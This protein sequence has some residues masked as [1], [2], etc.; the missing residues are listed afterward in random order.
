[1]NTVQLGTELAPVTAG[2]SVAANLYEP[3]VDQ[4]LAAGFKVLYG[5]PKAYPGGYAFSTMDT[6]TSTIKSKPKMVAAFV[7]SLGE[8]EAMIQQSPDTA[9]AVGEAQFPTLAKDIVDNAVQRLID[10]KVYATTPAISE[11]AFN[12]ALQLQVDV[13]N[14]KSGTVTYES[15]VNN[16]FAEAASK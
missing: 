10:Q 4:G 9:K 3:Q 12:N 7:K 8:A 13:G 1:L 11:A 16:T 5:F 6:L 14:I 15:A 2:R